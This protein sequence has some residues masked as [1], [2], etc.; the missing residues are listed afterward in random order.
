MDTHVTQQIV[1]THTACALNLKRKVVH[2]DLNPA[3]SNKEPNR[4]PDQGPE[5]DINGVGLEL[6]SNGFYQVH[7]DFDTIPL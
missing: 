1:L 4:R 5:R 3:P 7:I 2:S 6:N